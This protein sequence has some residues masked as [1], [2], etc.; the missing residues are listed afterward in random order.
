MDETDAFF[1]HTIVGAPFSVLL[2]RRQGA[3]TASQQGL[4]VSLTQG[5]VGLSKGWRSW[6]VLDHLDTPAG[7]PRRR[8]KR[9]R[10]WLE[11]HALVMA[12]LGLLMVLGSA[13]FWAIVWLPTT[14]WLP[15]NLLERWPWI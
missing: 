5:E 11:R 3:P 6:A 1:T 4:Q 8:P 12:L 7:T 15:A 14:G 10:R 9:M 2:G 13:V